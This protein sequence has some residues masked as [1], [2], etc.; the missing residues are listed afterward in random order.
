MA[1]VSESSIKHIRLEVLRQRP[2]Q[3]NGAKR[4]IRA[5]QPLRHRQNV[6]D[7]V[8]MIDREPFAGAAEA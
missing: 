7:D 1:V 3:S 2:P 4:H 6:G 8:P 5:R